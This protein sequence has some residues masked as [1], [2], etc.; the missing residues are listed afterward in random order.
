MGEWEFTGRQE[1]GLK[2]I[3]S[4]GQRSLLTR[5][6]GEG[7]HPRPRHRRHSRGVIEQAG[8]AARP[9]SRVTHSHSTKAIF[10][11]S[12]PETDRLEGTS[13]PQPTTAR[14]LEVSRGGCFIVFDGGGGG[15]CTY[16]FKSAIANLTCA[17]RAA[18][19]K[20]IKTRDIEPAL[21]VF[22]CRAE[23]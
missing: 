14:P 8:A 22:S 12:R 4:R 21:M 10:Q 2:D 1:G 5:R 15:R 19:V 17:R 7:P 9:R 11:M 3:S 6:G 20:L 16:L 13:E 18:P 23:I